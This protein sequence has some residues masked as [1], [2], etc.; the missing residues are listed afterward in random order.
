MASIE[1]GLVSI[2]SDWYLT[3]SGVDYN[4]DDG[5]LTWWQREAPYEA[6]EIIKGV[7]GIPNVR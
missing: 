1:Y 7:N 6:N 4:R 3:L 5:L 2:S